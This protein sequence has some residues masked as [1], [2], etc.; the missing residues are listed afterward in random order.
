MIEESGATAQEPRPEVT[1]LMSLNRNRSHIVFKVSAGFILPQELYSILA[2][3]T[4]YFG[5]LVHRGK[6]KELGRHVRVIHK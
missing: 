1:L 5:L 3:H 4:V 6:N 2:W